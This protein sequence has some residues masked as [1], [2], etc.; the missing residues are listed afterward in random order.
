[1]ELCF[2][3]NGGSGGQIL[4]QNQTIAVAAGCKANVPVRQECPQSGSGVVNHNGGL[5]LKEA[6]ASGAGQLD[7]DGVDRFGQQDVCDK[8]G[9]VEGGFLAV[10][11]GCGTGGSKASDRA[12]GIN[13][14][15]RVQVE[16]RPSAAYRGA[17]S[18]SQLICGGI[19]RTVGNHQGHVIALVCGRGL[20]QIHLK[21]I[22]LGFL[23]V[24]QPGDWSQVAVF[25]DA[26][27]SKAVQAVGVIG[28]EGNDNGAIAF[29]HCVQLRNDGLGQ[30]N[31][32]GHLHRLPVA[33]LPDS[34]LQTDGV[35][36]LR[37]GHI[38]AGLLV[39]N[40]SV[41]TPVIAAHSQSLAVYRG[42]R[43]GIHSQQSG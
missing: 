1:M 26:E 22:G 10:E 18:D 2:Q 3:G 5:P 16:Q 42:N 31:G 36:P 8:I 21:R 11:D 43:S 33:T 6:I 28:L 32:E 35:V 14:F 9:S 30:V 39:I 7:L 24:F 27:G 29:V 34:G 40:R 4:V 19:A 38:R 17:G 15:I 37:S 41:P 20:R 13:G 12:C 25:I 23:V